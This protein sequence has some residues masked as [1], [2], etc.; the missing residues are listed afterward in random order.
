MTREEKQRPVPINGRII[1]TFTNKATTTNMKPDTAAILN[2]VSINDYLEAIKSFEG[3]YYCWPTS[4]NKY[5]GKG[6]LYSIYINTKDCSGTVT[7]GLYRASGGTVDLRPTHNANALMGLCAEVAS[8]ATRAGDLVF[9][10]SGSRATHV[11]TVMGDGRV[12]G[13]SGGDSRT[14]SPTIAKA[15]NATVRYQKDYKYRKDLIR[16][17]RL[18]FKENQ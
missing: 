6:F 7:A 17:G 11:M 2:G 9:Y 13:A 8:D 10:G 15:M 5:S 18:P 4:E 3:E 14:V 16:F 1:L 12:Y